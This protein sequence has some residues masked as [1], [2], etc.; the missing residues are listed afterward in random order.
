MGD[1]LFRCNSISQNICTAVSGHGGGNGCG[2]LWKSS[3]LSLHSSVDK[4]LVSAS[5]AAGIPVMM[6]WQGT[7]EQAAQD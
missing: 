5:D 6:R 3:R 2:E 1:Q 7:S 4:A